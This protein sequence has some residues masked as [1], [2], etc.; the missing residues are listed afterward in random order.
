MG[1]REPVKEI[2][3]RIL[4]KDVTMASR[5]VLSKLFGAASTAS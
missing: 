1:R 2:C 5:L 4:A 3:L